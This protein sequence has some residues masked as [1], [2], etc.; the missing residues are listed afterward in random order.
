MTIVALAAAFFITALLYSS[1]G[2][3]G[4]STYNAL[5]AEGAA[6]KVDSPDE[7]TAK[8]GAWL[9]APDQARALGDKAAAAAE[10]ETAAFDQAW[11]ALQFLLPVA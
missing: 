11:R 3:G 2:F 7:L 5:L 9:D 1:V 4:G 6:V 8:L 10:R